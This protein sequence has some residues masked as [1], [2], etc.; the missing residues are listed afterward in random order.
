M[1]RFC[2]VTFM[3]AL[4]SSAM[5]ASATR[6]SGQQGGPRL[7]PAS[8]GFWWAGGAL[9]AVA[10]ASDAR[11]EQFSLEH[12]SPMLDDLGSVGNV[13]GTGRYLIPAIGASYVLGR[14]THRPHLT[15][16]TLHTALAYALG[17]VVTSVGKPVLGRHR[18]DTTGSAWRFHPLATGGEWHSLPS[19]HTVHAFTLAAAIS[20]EARRPWVTTLAYGAA[21][22][23]AWSRVYRDEHWASD[24]AISSVMG[25]AIG[26]VTVRALHARAARRRRTP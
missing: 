7:D 18:P 26:H 20:E 6:A 14:L 25:A 2:R 10:A 15:Q 12:R 5:V 16:G 22:L 11:F 17:N 23:V 3:T 21:T 13:L 1:R 19:A 4:A 8:P 24:V 9:V